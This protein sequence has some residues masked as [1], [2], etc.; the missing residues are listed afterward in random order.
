MFRISQYTDA[1]T[2]APDTLEWSQTVQANKCTNLG[3]HSSQWNCP[4]VYK[5]DCIYYTS[6]LAGNNCTVV[7]TATHWNYCNECKEMTL[8]QCNA[9]GS[10]AFLNCT[11]SACQNCPTVV[12]NFTAGSCV[13]GGVDALGFYDSAVMLMQAPAK[14]PQMYHQWYEGSNDCSSGRGW[15]YIALGACN[16]GWKFECL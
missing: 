4:A 1:V 8:R 10:F 3:D 2:C 16:N 9:D 6:Y 14:C 5:A 11:D 12:A 7:P 15:D 13:D